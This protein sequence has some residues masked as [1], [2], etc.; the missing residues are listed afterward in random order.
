MPI[1]AIMSYASVHAGVLACT[2]E[3]RPHKSCSPDFLSNDISLGY[4]ISGLDKQQVSLL[5][6]SW[7]GDSTV[8]SKDVLVAGNCKEHPGPGGGQGK[9]R[10]WGQRL[11]V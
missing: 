11:G 5:D 4:A 8:T 3:M 1:I 10:T 9:H 2:T 7:C 6:S